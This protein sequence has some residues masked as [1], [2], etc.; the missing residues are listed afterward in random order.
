[1][2]GGQQ[3]GVPV[4]V[5]LEVSVKGAS[6]ELG[7]QPLRA[8]QHV[9]LVARDERIHLRARQ[10]VSVAEREERVL[11]HRPGRGAGAVD[12]PRQHLGLAAGPQLR[13]ERVEAREVADPRF[14][15][16]A[17]EGG[18]VEGVGEVRERARG[19]GHRDAVVDR[20]VGVGEP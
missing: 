17:G 6:V 13:G 10:C 7:D 14:V 15:H 3:F 8:P 19:R 16:C 18:G 2:A 12:Q 20:D 1:M 5:A 4:P 11:E 9:D